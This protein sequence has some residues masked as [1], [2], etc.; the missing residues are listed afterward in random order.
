M[1][2]IILN[3]KKINSFIDELVRTVKDRAYTRKEIEKVL[4]K[5]DER[6][7]VMILLQTSAGLRIGALPELKIKHLKR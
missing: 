7:S 4:Q 5:C 6:K 2:D 3:W 1:N